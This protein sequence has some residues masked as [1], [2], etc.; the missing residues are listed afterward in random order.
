MSNPRQRQTTRVVCLSH[1]RSRV[2]GVDIH[3]AIA[4]SGE[5]LYLVHCAPKTIGLR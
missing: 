1:S 5:P 2:N 3:H 4:G